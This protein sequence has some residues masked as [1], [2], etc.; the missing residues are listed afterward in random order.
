M[1]SE[2]HSVPLTIV[3]GSGTVGSND[4]WSRA[5]IKYLPWQPAMKLHPQE[6][7]HY[8][9]DLVEENAAGVVGMEL[10]CSLVNKTTMEHAPTVEGG[11]HISD[12]DLRLGTRWGKV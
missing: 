9:V 5:H 10:D 8:T 1:S 4:S 2:A 12:W 7:S 6:V 3:E 11:A